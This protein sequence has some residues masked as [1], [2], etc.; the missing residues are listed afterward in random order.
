MSEQAAEGIWIAIGAYAL[1]GA[2]IAALVLPFGLGR[3]DANAARAPWRVKL[4]LAPGMIALWPIV[5]RRLAGAKPA[6]DQR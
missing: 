6:E 3:F 4:V 2:M 1:I 5:V